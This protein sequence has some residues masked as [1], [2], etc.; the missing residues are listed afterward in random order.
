MFPVRS[1]ALS[2]DSASA[3]F[4]GEFE[5]VFNVKR[6]EVREAIYKVFRSIQGIIF[7]TK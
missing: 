7:I 4:A 2:E 6:K 3:S 5:T 1:S